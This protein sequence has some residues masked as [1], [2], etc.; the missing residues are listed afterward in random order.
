MK[1]ILSLM[2]LLM[3]LT[4]CWKEVIEEIPEVKAEKT[5]YQVWVKENNF[6]NIYWNIVNSTLKVI[7]PNISGKVTTLNCEPWKK[8][9]AKT[10]IATISPNY[11][12]PAY[13]NSA[14]QN[15][16]LIEQIQ[17][18]NDIKS[19]TIENFESQKKQILLKKEELANSRT[20][21]SENIWDEKS[22][23]KNQE[24]IIDDS[25]ALLKQNNK[26]A[27]DDIKSQIANLRKNTY[28][29]LTKASKKLDEVYTIS[30]KNNHSNNDLKNYIWAKNNMLKYEL[31]EKSKE[32][33][34]FVEKTDENLSSIKDEE[35]AKK[36][37]EYSLIMKQAWDVIKDSLASNNELPQQLIDTN[38]AEFMW[39]SDW[40]LTIKNNLEKLL[41]AKE[42]T[43]TNFDLKLKE[44]ESKKS[45][46]SS[47]QTNL[48]NKENT[49]D[50]SEKNIDEQLDTLEE[51]KKTKLKEIDL[52]IL[53]AEQSLKST[54]INLKSENLYAETSWTIKT[55][56]AKAEGT[57]VQIWTPLCE[58]IPDNNSLKLEIFSPERL[59]I[60]DKFNFYKK[61]TQ[62][63]TGTII[64]EYPTKTEKTQNF[65]Y[66]WKIDFKDL[67]A[68]EYL[69]IKVLRQTSENEIWI[70]INFVSPK[71]DWYY[72]K[73]L[74]DWQVVNQK[75]EI[76]NMNNWEIQINSW[77][78]KWDILEK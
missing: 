14:V 2:L 41:N 10:L 29:T 3:I 33:I 61:W 17:K 13:Q 28:N 64:S 74:V 57:Q 38:F 43:K 62:I 8:V 58:I 34:N 1:K 11:D 25:I 49:I 5:N 52:Q 7:A 70:D 19:F 9:W 67:K 51:T 6:V 76:W 44:L 23:I 37:N 31:V 73:K 56:V 54:D 55:K 65:I 69:D 32:F 36:I 48:K 42:S 26:E 40:L 68:W 75:V 45:T 77:L 20:N 27:E 63:W 21:I 12:W 53:S 4:S 72:V 24:K 15:Q 50:I 18:L 46:L 30:D 16:A 59:N 39:Y 71:L 35:L 22:W 47:E 60:W 78:K 66:E